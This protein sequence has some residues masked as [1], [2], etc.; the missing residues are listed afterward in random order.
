[1]AHPL[2]EISADGKEVRCLNFQKNVN[3]SL[4]RFDTVNC[5]VARQSFSAGVCGLETRLEPGSHLKPSKDTWTADAEETLVVVR[6][7]L[8]R[9]LLDDQLQWAEGQEEVL[10]I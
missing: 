8:H 2:L 9:G 7:G 10:D 5:V 6:G 1:M 3:Y 4:Q